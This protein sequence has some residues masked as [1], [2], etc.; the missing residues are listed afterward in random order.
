M[1]GALLGLA[2]L[3][4]LLAFSLQPSSSLAQQPS[5]ELWFTVEFQGGGDFQ[6]I[7]DGVRVP[8]NQLGQLVWDFTWDVQPIEIYRSGAAYAEYN[9]SRGPDSSGSSFEQHAVFEGHYEASKQEFTGTYQ[10]SSSRTDQT[11]SYSEN[12]T[13]TLVGTLK[14]QGLV[15]QPTIF[16]MRGTIHCVGT[17]VRVDL[18]DDGED[19]S[20][21]KSMEIIW[22]FVAHGDTGPEIKEQSGAQEDGTQSN[23]ASGSKI[24]GPGSW[25]DWLKGTAVAGIVV[26]GLGLIGGRSGTAPATPGPKKNVPPPDAPRLEQAGPY[27]ERPP[28]LLDAAKKA[29]DDMVEIGGLFA[30][31][32]KNDVVSVPGYISDKAKWAYNGV[33]NPDTWESAKEGFDKFVNLPFD[34]WKAARDL[35]D[36]PE[37]WEQARVDAA[38]KILTV[39]DA[40]KKEVADNPWGVI[41]TIIGADLWEKATDPKVPVVERLGYSAIA[42]LNTIGL[43]EGGAALKNWVA[44]GGGKT[45]TGLIEE[46]LSG[47]RT[48]DKVDDAGR[49]VTTA[50]KVD[51]TVDAGKAV[52]TAEKTGASGAA[53][54]MRKPEGLRGLSDAAKIEQTEA[55]KTARDAA[56]TK[57]DEFNQARK[58]HN[59]QETIDKVLEVRKDPLAVQ[60]LNTRQPG[61]MKSFNKELGKL[62]A[63]SIEAA[64]ERLAQ[65][66]GVGRDSIQ[67]VKATNPSSVVKSGMDTDFTFRVTKA[68]HVLTPDPANP[69]KYVW[70]PQTGAVASDVPAPLAQSTYDDA[71]YDRAGRPAGTTPEQLGR[72]MRNVAVDRA[73]PEAYGDPSDLKAVMKGEAPPSPQRVADT[74]V[75][76]SQE[77]FAA[78]AKL[79]KEGRAQE[80]MTERMMGTRE[81]VKSFKNQ[82]EQRVAAIKKT[83][84]GAAKVASLQDQLDKLRGPT[85]QLDKMIKS[86]ASP[87]EMDDYLMRTTGKTVEGLNHDIADLYVKLCQP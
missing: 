16:T 80:A 12:F 55:W 32:V 31:N 7:V 62:Q 3:L 4:L 19:E 67:V 71:F 63:D 36:D 15:D 78:E 33:T 21:S 47:G 10:A 34:L 39:T 8:G 30:E 41:K 38:D 49:V 17:A 84:G 18:V 11:S 40:V 56:K 44:G 26:T 73:S 70:S 24:P 77:H 61:V 83:P 60:D 69:G 72:D 53:E 9:V 1:S 59:A 29:H 51:T 45:A 37:K 74:I 75:H 52:G 58:G 68:N 87:M 6:L 2:V 13:G 66:L 46:V 76:K 42:V 23:G 20:F 85:K 25:W 28:G 50:G 57:V 48:I 65:E 82:I 79:V 5:E 14:S 27:H 81:T 43:I 86:G 54:T 22:D 64:K 35:H